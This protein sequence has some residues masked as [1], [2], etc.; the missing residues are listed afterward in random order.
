[1]FAYGTTTFCDD[2][3]KEVGGKRSFIGVYNTNLVTKSAAPVV[4]PQLGI[5]MLLIIPGGYKKTESAEVIFKVFMESDTQRRQLFESATRQVR[6]TKDPER[7]S[8]AGADVVVQ[9]LVLEADCLIK[10]RAYLD[11]E[12]IKLGSLVVMFE[13]DPRQQE[14]KREKAPESI[15]PLLG[16]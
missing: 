14:K 10:A 9:P 7:I 5:S 4:V 16:G 3:R 15:V 1:M 11:G 8:K 12:E 2:I 6:M 13:G